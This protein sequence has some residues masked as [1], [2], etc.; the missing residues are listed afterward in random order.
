MDFESYKFA[1]LSPDMRTEMY[2]K[3]SE[4]DHDCQQKIIWPNKKTAAIN[5]V[6]ACEKTLLKH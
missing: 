3:Y 4:G 2:K 5:T 6:S 1:F